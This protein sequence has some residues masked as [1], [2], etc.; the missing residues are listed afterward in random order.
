MTDP[1]QLM[2]NECTMMLTGSTGS[3]VTPWPKASAFLHGR[4]G[5]ALSQFRR[6]FPEAIKRRDRIECTLHE[7]LEAGGG[8]LVLDHDQCRSGVGWLVGCGIWGG[9]GGLGDLGIGG[10]LGWVG[11]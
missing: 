6:F 8:S 5:K 9:I 1:I 10:N 2:R 4:G 11:G 3:P 7:W